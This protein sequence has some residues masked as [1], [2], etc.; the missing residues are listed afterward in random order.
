[1][2][3][4]LAIIIGGVIGWLYSYA[5]EPERR[6]YVADIIGG[7]IGAII[8]VWFFAN[9]L[10]LG[11]P[12]VTDIGTISLLG[13]IWSIVG[14]VVFAAIVQSAIPESDRGYMRQTG[15]AYYQEVRRERRMEKE[16]KDRKTDDQ[17]ENL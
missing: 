3:W 6:N 2:S 13:V 5:V 7:A 10:G 1:M 16:D 11:F 14:G 8:G 12:L 17:D 4:L 9:V 15:P